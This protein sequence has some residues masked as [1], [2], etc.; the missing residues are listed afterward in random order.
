MF[1]EHSIKC[2]VVV[3]F[4]IVVYVLNYLDKIRILDPSYKYKLVKKQNKIKLR[5]SEELKH[6]LMAFPVSNNME[7]IRKFVILEV[8]E[9]HNFI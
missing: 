2:F 6:R 8:P 3:G 9:F 7:D 4:S 1:E 5:K